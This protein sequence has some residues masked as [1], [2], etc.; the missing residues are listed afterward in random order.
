M[1]HLAKGEHEMP[2]DTSIKILVVDD[3][4]TM[5]RI[6]RGVLKQIGFTKIIE[7]VDGNN[8]LETLKKESDIKLIVSDWNIPNM[9]GLE[10]LKAHTFDGQGAKVGFPTTL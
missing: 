9:T 10:L 4:A 5:R 3:F 1:T 7:A 2:L 6:V 8:A